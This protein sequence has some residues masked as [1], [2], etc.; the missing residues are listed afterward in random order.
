MNRRRAI[1]MVGA[2]AVVLA[3]AAAC[4]KGEPGGGG[5]TT[6]AGGTTTAGSPTTSGG[7]PT[8]SGGGSEKGTV[9]AENVGA[10]GVVLVDSKGFTLYRLEGETASNIMCT[11]GCAQTWPPLKASGSPKAGQGATGKIGT[12]MRSDGITQVTYDGVPLYR[13]AADSQPGQANGEGV[14][15]VWFAV[16]PA[17]ESAKGGSAGGGMSPTGS[18]YYR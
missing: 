10:L 9:R 17:G 4:G 12:V 2:M 18:G 6:I 16:T 7:G 8:T 15:G 3:L 1:C 5:S 13:Y 14:A 11:G